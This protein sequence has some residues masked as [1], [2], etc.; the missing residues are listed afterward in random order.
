MQFFRPQKEYD[1]QIEN[2]TW[3]LVNLP[4]NGRAIGCH[5]VFTIKMSQDPVVY[6]A[7]LVAQGFR[8]VKGLDHFETFSPVVSYDSIRFLLAISSHFHFQ[9]HQID[10]TTAF[11]NGILD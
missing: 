10:V 8:Q 2:R 11:L 1:A 6:K 5:W 7:R 4:P 9:I 3:T